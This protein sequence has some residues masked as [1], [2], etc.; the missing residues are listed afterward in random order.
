MSTADTLQPRSG[1]HTLPDRPPPA[2][3]LSADA[4]RGLASLALA[5]L[6][7]AL[8]V[9]VLGWPSGEAAL[10]A[11]PP[12][13]DVDAGAD[14]TASSVLVPPASESASEVVVVDVDGAVRRP[15]VVELPGGSRVVDALDAAGGVQRR[16]DTGALNLAQVLLDGEQV[17][18]PR[19]GAGGA[20]DPVAVASPA[21]GSVSTPGLVN[22][23]TAN[24]VELDALPGI[25][26][27]LA[28]AI[29]EWRTQNG[30]FTSLEQL[31]DVSGIGPATFAELAPLV[32]L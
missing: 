32:R 9:V 21:P 8:V 17:V 30:G 3:R 12:Q 4:V 25:G 5:A 18:V 2:W 13:L 28:A 6:V 10:D 22:I 27:V 19:A 23:N 15:G 16:A 14:A 29:V 24:E 1:R 26:P 7:G 31:Q 20:A 11:A